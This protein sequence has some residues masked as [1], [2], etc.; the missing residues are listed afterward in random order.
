VIFGLLVL[1]LR[2]N[3]IY[4]VKSKARAKGCNSLIDLDTY[5]SVFSVFFGVSLVDVIGI[6]HKRKD[7]HL[8]YVYGLRKVVGLNIIQ[9]SE[10]LG[11][12]NYFTVSFSIKE[13]CKKLCP[14]DVSY[15]I[16]FTE[17]W[18]SFVSYCRLFRKPLSSAER[19]KRFRD[20]QR[21]KKKRAKA[22]GKK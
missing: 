14:Y 18:R 10:L 6:E 12:P 20:K 5:N 13:C 3:I 7:V 9:S 2:Y 4:M 17:R 1:D 21:N 15:S 16:E 8:W 19:S 22:K 11:F